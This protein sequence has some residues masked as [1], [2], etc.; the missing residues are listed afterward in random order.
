MFQSV[1]HLRNLRSPHWGARG[2]TVHVDEILNV[3]KACPHLVSLSLGK[4]NVVNVGHDP[5]LPPS[6]LPKHSDPP[7]P[8]VPIPDEEFD[9][10]SSGNRLQQLVFNGTKINDEGLLRLLGL[11]LKPAHNAHRC[12]ALIR[13][14]VYS[15]GP[16]HKSGARILQECERL[17]VMSVQSSRI[18]SFEL[19][20]GDVVW[21]SAPLIKE[22]SL[23]FKLKG[24][25]PHLYDNH[26]YAL[27]DGGQGVLSHGAAPIH[28]SGSG[29]PASYE[30]KMIFMLV[31]CGK[32]APRSDLTEASRP[33][34]FPYKMRTS[35][36]LSLLASTFLLTAQGSQSFYEGL[37][38]HENFI[39]ANGYG[40]DRW[41]CSF[42][43]SQVHESSS[44]TYITIGTDSDLKPY[45]C[46]ELIYRQED[47]G[48]GVYSIDMIA[49]NVVGQVTSFFLIANEDTEIDVELT[50]LN[51]HIGWMN[52]WHDQKQ[53]PISIDLPFDTSEDWH[54]Y[55]FEWRR[56]FVAWSVDGHV[57]LNRTDI[58]TSSPS[59][60]NYRLAINSWTQVNDENIQ[61]AGQFSYPVDGRVPHAQ[62]RNIRYDP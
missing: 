58:P 51:N 15:C 41:G 43:D 13:L 38:T 18:A 52:I 36:V 62:F 34:P 46:G 56:D 26:P 1:A 11:A 60:T 31:P 53:N 30:T 10:L 6:P 22:L 49:S 50:G 37:T 9:M 16:T 23:D 2:T 28:T 35:I 32:A 5:P 19:F 39:V 21:P 20:E 14:D 7:G 17:E 45:S 8:F 4:V 61:W 40:P 59:D 33:P 3:L 27:Q 55:S 54:T 12:P 25:N 29:T 24:V 57:V 48:Y 44:G 42:T 47:M